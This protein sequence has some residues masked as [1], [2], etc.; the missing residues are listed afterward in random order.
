MTFPTQTNPNNNKFQ[1][2][3][4]FIVTER[5][6]TCLRELKFVE[7]WI[8][9]YSS[10]HRKKCPSQT[11]SRLRNNFWFACM[12]TQGTKLQFPHSK[13]WNGCGMK[14]QTKAEKKSQGM[15]TC[16]NLSCAFPRSFKGIFINSL[17]K[18]EEN[19]EISEN[20]FFSSCLSL[21]I[22]FISYFNRLKKL[23]V[24]VV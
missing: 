18:K 23:L 8:F 2:L 22:A 9:M 6:K 17:R 4:R 19:E 7:L 3:Y 11:W 12:H 20:F 1:F 13:P 5:I 16:I 21:S 10:L 15:K 14:E 24:N